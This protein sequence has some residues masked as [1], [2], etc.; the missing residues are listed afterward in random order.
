[1]ARAHHVNKARKDNP[2]AKAGESYYWW[3]FRFGGRHYSKTEPK[4]SQLTQSPYL[5]VIYSCEEQWENLDDPTG[6]DPEQ[7]DV[8]Y[9]VTWLGEIADSMESIKDELYELV[10][11]YEEAA[12]NM[13][14]YFSGAE[15]VD[16]LR[17]AGM[18]CD[19][20]CSEIEQSYDSIRDAATAIGEIK[21]PDDEIEGA[22]DEY[23]EA[24]YE[25]I[26]DIDVCEPNF[27]F[28]EL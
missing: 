3:K 15:R 7:W 14:E 9:I 22:V 10:A 16:Q 28:H 13:E 2:V 17:D 18:A 23:N 24:A 25:F 21:Q 4:A 6:L 8:G 12:E 11:Q 27:D 20:T 26:A 5:S 19:D 1:M